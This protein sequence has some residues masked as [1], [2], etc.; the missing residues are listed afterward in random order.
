MLSFAFV[1]VMLSAAILNVIMTIFV[2][3]NV[4]TLKVFILIVVM[5][6]VLAPFIRLEDYL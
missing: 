2:I 4:D 6:T 1:T 3:L 5:L